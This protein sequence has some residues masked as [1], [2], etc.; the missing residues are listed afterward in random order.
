M[1][2]FL[3]LVS[4]FVVLAACTSQTARED[5]AEIVQAT[6][7]LPQPTEPEPTDTATAVSTNTA[8]VAPTNTATARPTGTATMTAT[9]T[10]T[11]SPT[12]TSLPPAVATEQVYIGHLESFFETHNRLIE[13]LS[14]HFIN[15]GDATD[16][17]SWQAAGQGIIKNILLNNSQ[18]RAVEPPDQYQPAHSFF[19]AGVDHVDAA[20][21]VYSSV[22]ADLD[23]GLA[24]QGHEHLRLAVEALDT[25][26]QVFDAI[27]SGT[28]VEPTATAV[29]LPTN[30]TTP[31]PTWTLA[32][33]TA[34]QAPLP[35]Q[36]LPTDTPLPTAVPLP[37]IPPATAT[38][39][40]GVCSCS[41][42]TLNCG[43]FSSHA[44]AQ[45]CFNY[46]VQQGA[47]DIHRLD[48]DNDGDACE[49][50]P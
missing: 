48:Q 29:F 38:S 27:R 34:T 12:A 13:E 18:L 33:P 22:L 45:A 24:E 8:T 42:D 6:E 41:G 15:A 26:S 14:Q 7:P 46:C 4:I 31:L 9:P 49:S 32:A 19:L 35:T 37:T 21:D 10:K 30:T 47:G 20:M 16:V 1:K 39:A 11:S 28:Y 36:P 3:V 23:T 5:G 44:A 50:L 40:P 2:K 25:G 17:S 43:D